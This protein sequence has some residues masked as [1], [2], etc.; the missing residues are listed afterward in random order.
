MQADERHSLA[1]KKSN[2]HWEAE[3]IDSESKF[4]ISHIQG[5]R[6]VSL[7]KR[8]M[9]DT[10][11]RVADP[12]QVAFFSDGF[13]SYKTLFPQIFGYPYQPPATLIWVAQYAIVFLA[14][15]LMFKLSS[16]VKEKNGTL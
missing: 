9:R 14:V 7:I 10:A 13:V 5:E 4:V 6:N 16:I 2:L 3:V 11:Q 1:G 12:H 15:L 8:V